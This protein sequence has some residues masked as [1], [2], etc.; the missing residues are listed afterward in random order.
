MSSCPE[1]GIGACAVTMTKCRTKTLVLLE[2]V[3]TV[4]IE[5]HFTSIT[6]QRNLPFTWSPTPF[7]YY[8]GTPPARSMCKPPQ[9]PGR[10]V[11]NVNCKCT[12]LAY[13]MILLIQ[14]RQSNAG[15]LSIAT[16]LT[17]ANE[18]WKSLWDS[19]SFS[20]VTKV[21]ALILQQCWVVCVHSFFFHLCQI[22]IIL[23]VRNTH[24]NAR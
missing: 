5:S 6:I 11:T 2:G 3:E 14:I 9:A 20:V 10:L 18:G 13:S 1:L 8:T 23:H 22:N 15:D 17:T 19:L 16:A 24:W 12:C 21:P 4:P 7:V